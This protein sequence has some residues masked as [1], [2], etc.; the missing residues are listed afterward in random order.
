MSQL[1]NDKQMLAYDSLQSYANISCFTTTRHGG[2]SSGTYASFNC[3]DY[4]GDH[5]ESVAANQ[6]LLITRL[7]LPS[8]ELVLPRQTHGS[9]VRVIDEAYGLL[10][11][12]AKKA[13]LYGVDALVTNV[14]GYCIAVST[15][16]C[17]PILLYDTENC[18]IGVV[19]A[20]WRG[21]VSKLLT[22]T[23]SVM[24]AT[25]GTNPI[26]LKACIGPSISLAAFEVGEEVYDAFR[27][28]RFPIEKLSWWNEA[29]QKW[30]LDLWEA[31]RWLLTQ[32]GI[33]ANQV[34]VSGIC[35]VQQVDD[36][37]SARQLGIASGRI[38]SG[39]VL[40]SKIE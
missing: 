7:S 1:T 12:E 33:E 34:E 5:E 37:F 8:V 16:D 2:C 21:T 28:A 30:H 18:A 6:Q 35:T 39:I 29:T 10:T 17:V 3:T 32:G 24:T 26:F 15:A 27:E 23:I 25:Y 36:F 22:E 38:L 4:C 20:G 9:V 13:L 31:N 19:H 14:P 11:A 40:H